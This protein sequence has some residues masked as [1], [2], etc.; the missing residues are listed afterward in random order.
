MMADYAATLLVPA[1]AT[2][3]TISGVPGASGDLTVDG[4]GHVVVKT[5]RA[6]RYLLSQG[7]TTVSV[8]VPSGGGNQG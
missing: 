4:S 1:G 2:L 3:M 5:Q 6:T 7:W 8:T